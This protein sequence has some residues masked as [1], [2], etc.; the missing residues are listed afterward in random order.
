MITARTQIKQ[1]MKE[2]GTDVDNIANDFI[3]RLDEKV[4]EIVINACRRAK[5][6]NRKTLMARDV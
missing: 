1:I 2:S 5:E 6:N 4:K 3:D